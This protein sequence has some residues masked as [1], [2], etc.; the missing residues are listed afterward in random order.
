ME[1]TVTIPVQDISLEGQFFPG[2]GGGGA[3]ITHP[4]PLY[5]G[6]LDNNVVWTAARAFQEAHLSTLRVNFRGVGRSTGSYGQ[7]LKE[8]EDVAAALAFLKAHQPGPYYLVGYSFGGAVAARAM[9]Q[10]VEAHGLWLIAPPIAFMDLAFLPETPRLQV[11]VVGD[12]DELC[13]LNELEALIKPIREQL[14]LEVIPGCNHFF[15]GH[16]SRLFQVLKKFL[17][18][19]PA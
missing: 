8:V 11:I 7:G 2:R 13:P 5:G 6:S 18:K 10:G 9:L 16:E 12:Q 4:H 17:E 3:V 14:T 15:G 19:S 1:E